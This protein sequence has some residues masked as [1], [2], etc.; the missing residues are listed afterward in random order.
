MWFVTTVVDTAIG[1]FVI[2]TRISSGDNEKAMPPPKT[3][4]LT[5]NDMI[6]LACAEN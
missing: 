2:Q 5:R 4:R 3:T 1:L 6:N